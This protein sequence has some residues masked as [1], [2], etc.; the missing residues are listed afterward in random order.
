VGRLQ[1][2]AAELLD[3]NGAVVE[4]IDPDGLDVLAPPHVQGALQI[5]E[6]CRLGFGPVLPP[7]AQRVGIEADW[8]DRFGRLIGERGRCIR[9]V[10]QADNRPVSDPSRMLEHE[11]ELANAPFRLL[12]VSPAWTRYLILDFRL[13]ALSDEKRDGLLRLGVN[14][15]TSA[16]L[17]GVL[18]EMAPWLVGTGADAALPP[19]TELPPSWDRQE[20]L[21]LIHRALHSRLE[22]LVEPFASS[23]RRRLA[24]DQE[25]LYSYHNELYCEAMRRIAMLPDGNDAHRREQ[26]R[27][28]AIARE[29]RAKLDDLAHKYAMRVTLEWVQTLDLAM[30]VQRFT[31]LVRR[32]K[33]ERVIKLDWNPLARRLESPPCEFSGAAERPRLLCDD[34]LHLV[35][36]PGLAGCPGCGKP[37]CRACRPDKCPRCGHT[38]HVA[39]S[40]WVSK[41]PHESAPSESA[42]GA[43]A[44]TIA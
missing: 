38:A 30:P 19:G 10:V 14:L 17:D 16:M 25:R 15:A 4:A 42:R 43:P 29:Y 41:R 26:Q 11:L 21:A 8:L 1:Q 2:F 23:L 22:R 28:E 27:S 18:E 32:R 39:R 13:T 3:H 31:V 12:E 9:R 44:R 37:Y 7:G 20:L 5:P 33:A 35:S 34:A 6:L 24:R 40:M 36:P